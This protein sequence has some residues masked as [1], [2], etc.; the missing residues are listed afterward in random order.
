MGLEQALA[1]VIRTTD[2][3]QTARWKAAEAGGEAACVRFQ[4]ALWG[5]PKA[6]RDLCHSQI[7]AGLGWH[8]RRERW[9]GVCFWAGG[10]DLKH[11]VRTHESAFMLKCVCANID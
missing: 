10:C 9:S 2:R 3:I 11:Q 8:L 1:K 6:G 7:C 4:P 5:L